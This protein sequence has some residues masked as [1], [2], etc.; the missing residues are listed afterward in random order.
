MKKNVLILGMAFFF[1]MPFFA[2][3]TESPTV[4]EEAVSEVTEEAVVD[5]ADENPSEETTKLIFISADGDDFPVYSY[6]IKGSKLT[7]SFLC[8][9]NDTITVP[10]S[11]FY[12]TSADGNYKVILNRQQ[13]I[14]DG[15]VQTWR[16]KKGNKAAIGWGLALTWVGALSAALC[17]EMLISDATINHF[18]W[19]TAAGLGSG[20]GLTIFGVSLSNSGAGK[21]VRIE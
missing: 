10:N 1:V 19:R 18:D 9:S 13:I 20:I 15:G 6:V 2:Q 12:V 7:S 17:G 5:V 3:E 14:P 11:P 4:I 8:D 21:F 16:V